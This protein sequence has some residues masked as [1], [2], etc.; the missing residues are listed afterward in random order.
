MVGSV[1]RPT[2]QV[3]IAPNLPRECDVDM[4]GI[5]GSSYRPHLCSPSSS[6]RL[7]RA[8]E[9]QSSLE[10]SEWSKEV[11]KKA[12]EAIAK[13]FIY[14]NLPFSA[15]R[16]PYWE[17]FVTA[18]TSAGEGFKAPSSRDLSGRML[19]DAVEDAKQAVEDQK[20]QWQK[21]IEIL[22]VTEP[23]LYE[24]EPPKNQVHEVEAEE[25]SLPSSSRVEPQAQSS[26]PS[27]EPQSS[28]RNILERG[29]RKL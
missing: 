22:K 8:R 6:S 7:S 4:Q 25:D 15:T 23:L 11:Y 17:D 5:M 3:A 19:Q 1:E 26:R 29:K 28:V 24:E 9:A 13:F 20:K 10:A 18:V 16:S 14:C 27:R 21:A 2:E 12:D